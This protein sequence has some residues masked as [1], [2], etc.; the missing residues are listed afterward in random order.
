[1]FDPSLPDEVRETLSAAPD[2]LLSAREQPERPGSG[3]AERKERAPLSTGGRVFLGIALLVLTGLLSGAVLWLTT[4]LMPL[5]WLIAALLALVGV[6]MAFRA[7]GCW[8]GLLSIVLVVAA[9]VVADLLG[10]AGV[11]W[12]ITGVVALLGVLITLSAV[13]GDGAR[14]T[15]GFGIDAAEAARLYHDRYVLPS[16]LREAELG[17]LRRV[18]RA[19]QRIEPASR[20]LG[21]AFDGLH[22]DL[23]LREQEWRLARLLLKQS[24]L[25]ADLHERSQEAVSDVVRASLRPQQDAVDASCRALTSR[26]EAIEPTAARSN[27]PRPPSGNG[28]RSRPTRPGTTST[29]SCSRRRPPTCPGPTTCTTTRNC[30][31]CARSAT[32]PSVRLWRPVSG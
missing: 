31:P 18:R 3:A 24:R 19:R 11:S 21:D 20:E 8:I 4:A 25:R 7:G 13:L 28:F 5:I 12:L 10:S 14:G 30:G 29:A 6:I 17:L 22:A 23:V 15:G 27:E 16:D 26:V 32:P 9:L 2:A 1:M